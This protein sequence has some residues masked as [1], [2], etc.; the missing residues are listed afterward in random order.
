MKIKSFEVTGL[1]GRISPIKLDFYPDINILTGRNGAGKTSLLKLI[2]YIVSGNLLLALREVGFQK[3]T[4]ITDKYECTVYRTGRATCRIDFFDGSHRQTFED[5]SDDEGD[6]IFNAE[7]E[8]NPIL[9]KTGSSVF[10][11]T[12][13]RI[14][15]GF[16]LNAAATRNN[17]SGGIFG[18]PL[19]RSGRDKNEVED[20]LSEL[21][22]RLTNNNH[23]FVTS[24]STVDITNILMAA[25]TNLSEVYNSLQRSMSQEIVD[26]I[27][28]RKP[29][30]G[31]AAE[32]NEANDILDSIRTKI[33][34]VEDNRESIMA[35]IE[36]IQNTV[37][38][39]FRHSGIKFSER[40]SFGDAALAVNSDSL[41]AGEKQMLS[42]ISYN[43]L[44]KD[45][46]F[47]IDEPELSLHVDWQRQLF[48]TLISQQASNQFIIATHSPFIYGKYPENEIRIDPDRGDG[49]DNA[50]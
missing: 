32:L 24:I 5:I 46:I 28:Q 33:E 18:N 8:A 43:G 47:L 37:K 23:V 34:K 48:P 13:R 39:M 1:I 6:V 27:R 22:R 50:Q 38:M 12:F 40:L 21:A 44:Y 31:G 10:L 2:W 7:D 35:P 3:A 42:F 17:L 20:G 19:V 29:S 15:G 36:A 41:S 16:S 11:P 9:R 49:G 14:E 25:Y 4:I 26:T 30:T 45:A